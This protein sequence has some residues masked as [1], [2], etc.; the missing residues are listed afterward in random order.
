MIHRRGYLARPSLPSYICRGDN[1]SASTRFAQASL[2][3][4]QHFSDSAHWLTQTGVLSSLIAKQIIASIQVPIAQQELD[5]PHAYNP[6]A[7]PLHM[8]S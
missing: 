7:F 1:L 5:K 4:P 2:W 6:V 3:L 8:S